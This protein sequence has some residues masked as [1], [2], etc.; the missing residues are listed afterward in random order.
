MTAVQKAGLFCLRGPRKV[1]TT[2]PAGMESKNRLY[3]NTEGIKGLTTE[4][5]AKSFPLSLSDNW[6]KY[7]IMQPIPKEFR[8]F[9]LEGLHS[10][11]KHQTVCYTVHIYLPVNMLTQVYVVFTQGDIAIYNGIGKLHQRVMLIKLPN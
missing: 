10:K 4:Q 7:H 1:L 8:Y 11:G 3:S 2:Q 9:S 6:Q 5:L